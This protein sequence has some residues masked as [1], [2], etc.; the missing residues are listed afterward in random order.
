MKKSLFLT[1]LLFL[2]ACHSSDD[3]FKVDY[4]KVSFVGQ[5]NKMGEPVEKNVQECV[6]FSKA[7]IEKSKIFEADSQQLDFHC[8][9]VNANL[10]HV[11]DMNGAKELNE[12]CR[13]W[14]DEFYKAK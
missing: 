12:K 5:T 6:A 4:S 9:C 2:A 11:E 1:L 14:T 8:R 7:E 3:S 10:D 13:A